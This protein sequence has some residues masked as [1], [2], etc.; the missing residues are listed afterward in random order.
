[1]GKQAEDK[2]GRFLLVSQIY[3]QDIFF[4]SRLFLCYNIYVFIISRNQ[5]YE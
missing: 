1:M 3:P 2:A 4:H 5:F